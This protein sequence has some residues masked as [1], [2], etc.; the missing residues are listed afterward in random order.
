MSGENSFRLRAKSNYT[1]FLTHAYTKSEIIIIIA[2]FVGI[3]LMVVSLLTQMAV[4][5]INFAPKAA[6]LRATKLTP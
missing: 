3:P 5:G 2:L 4:G 1:I 6:T